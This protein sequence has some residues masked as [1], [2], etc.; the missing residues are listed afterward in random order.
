MRHMQCEPSIRSKVR[1]FYLAYDII[2]YVNIRAVYTCVCS[3]QSVLMHVSVDV[4]AGFLCPTLCVYTTHDI[5]HTTRPTACA[6]V[7]TRQHFTNS[8]HITSTLSLLC[9]IYY[10]RAYWIFPQIHVCL[11]TRLVYVCI[12]MSVLRGQLLHVVSMTF[13]GHNVR[14]IW[15]S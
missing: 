11:C 5:R 8:A 7:S 3:L 1:T 13:Q 6:R 15:V 12:S 2:K 4:W 14:G 9:C 10:W